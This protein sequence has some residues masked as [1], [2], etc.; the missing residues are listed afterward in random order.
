MKHGQYG[1]ANSLS[2]D[3]E[4]LHVLSKLKVYYLV[5][6][7]LPTNSIPNKMDTGYFLEPTLM[8]TSI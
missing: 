8:H 5:Y 4:I 1:E 2:A 3:Q 7:S 6:M